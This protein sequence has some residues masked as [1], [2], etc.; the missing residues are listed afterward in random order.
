MAGGEGTISFISSSLPV[1][2]SRR[3]K[4]MNFCHR[5]SEGAHLGTTTKSARKRSA[6][7]SGAPAAAARR[8]HAFWGSFG[9]FGHPHLLRL[10]LRT[11]PR[12]GGGSKMRPDRLS[13]FRRRARRFTFSGLSSF[14]PST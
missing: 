1:Y 10:V 12:S 13:C 4:T 14:P 3:G 11:Q 2:V 9:D 5:R 7:Y 8:G 6:A